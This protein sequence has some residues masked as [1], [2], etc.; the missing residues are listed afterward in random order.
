MKL[1]I[2]PDILDVVG[3]ALRLS[4]RIRR[5]NKHLAEQIDR[6]APAIALNAAEGWSQRGG[7]KAVRYGHACGEAEETRTALEVA[8]IAHYIPRLDQAF[9]DK[10]DRVIGTLYRL[11]H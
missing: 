1:R 6:S 10:I 9:V 11:S 4:K 8:V 7:N 3:Q 2:Y 5:H